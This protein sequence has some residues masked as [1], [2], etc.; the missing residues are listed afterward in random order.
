MTHIHYNVISTHV[1]GT[2]TEADSFAELE[3]DVNAL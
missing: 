1:N 3:A 2:N